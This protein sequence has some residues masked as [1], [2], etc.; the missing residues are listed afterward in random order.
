MNKEKG[1]GFIR[2]DYRHNAEMAK[3]SLD[4]KLLKGRNISVRYATHASAVELHGL[5][6]YASNEFI[7][8][9]MSSFGAVE[10]CVVVCD[11]RGR[12]KGYAIVEFEWKKSAAKVLDRLKD[13]M[14]VLGRC[15]I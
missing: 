8:R 5:D 15:S 2:L 12:S 13:E 4:K 6:N 3:L 7:G 1:F 11:D 9:A 14:F 10:R